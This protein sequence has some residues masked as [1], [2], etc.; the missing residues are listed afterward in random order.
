MAWGK[1]SPGEIDF[2]VQGILPEQ[3][4]AGNRFIAYGY[5]SRPD[6]LENG[7]VLDLDFSLLRLR[8][9][10]LPVDN[11]DR[12]PPCLGS[13]REINNGLADNDSHDPD[14]CL[15]QPELM[16]G[17]CPLGRRESLVRRK[18]GVICDHRDEMLRWLDTRSSDRLNQCRCNASNYQCD[19]DYSRASSI[20][21]SS[22]PNHPSGRS[23]DLTCYN[24]ASNARA[25]CAGRFFGT[26]GYRF[27]PG[28]S[29]ILKDGI[30]LLPTT[31]PCNES[32]A[33]TVLS[34]FSGTVASVIGYALQL[35]LLFFF[36]ILILGWIRTRG[37]A[38]PPKVISAAF[39]VGVSIFLAIQAAGW[40]V[41]NSI[42]LVGGWILSWFR[43][44]DMETQFPRNRSSETR[45]WTSGLYSSVASSPSRRSRVIDIPDPEDPPRAFLRPP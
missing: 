7:I 20:A 33:I 37:S 44:K 22:D 16:L 1:I 17:W 5:S 35:L 41:W 19:V 28:T 34:H 23:P 12:L 29:C 31:Q 8:P 3:D 40:L 32:Q 43:S 42:R 2:Q 26:Q 25:F 4:A 9:C 11:L 13:V 45:E 24:A 10:E 27:A 38:D 14:Y 18:R 36:V 6:G 30:N 39:D 21:L 15:F